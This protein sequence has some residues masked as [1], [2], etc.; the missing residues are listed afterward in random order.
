MDAGLAFLIL[1][2]SGVYFMILR[3]VFAPRRP[4][5]SKYAAITVTAAMLIAA[6]AWYADETIFRP[7]SSEQ[8]L[9]SLLHISDVLILLA[10]IML[11]IGIIGEYPDDEEWKKTLLYTICKLLVVAGVGIE[12]LADSG[13]FSASDRLH[14]IDQN[15]INIAR[16]DAAKAIDDAAKANERAKALDKDEIKA[17]LELE[18]LKAANL[19]L[20]AQI[21]P[22]NLNP[23]QAEQIVTAARRHAGEHI[24]LLSYSMD[25]EAA[26]LGEE[27]A[28]LFRANNIPLDD[29][30]MS[31]SALGS[32]SAGLRVS[33]TDAGFATEI[34]SALNNG[35]AAVIEGPPPMSTGITVGDPNAPAPVKIF[36]GVKPL[37]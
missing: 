12:L 18:R 5:N 3:D 25:F 19:S 11:V 22:R 29:R 20:Q 36:I 7:A 14:D 31:I 33:G 8:E 24:M 26:R 13:I 15:K 35:L 2:V 32:I 23:T 34:I 17:Q 37:P 4:I 1:V 28:R 30:R 6:A 27:F 10:A 16:T 9:L 21:Q